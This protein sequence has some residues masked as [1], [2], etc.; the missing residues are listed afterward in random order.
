MF[1]D[2]NL[3]WYPSIV[4]SN[5]KQITIGDLHSNA[6][7]LV[8]ILIRHQVLKVSVT[9]YLKLVGCYQSLA[10]NPQDEY[11]YHEF[12]KIIYEAEVVNKPLIRMIGDE[13]A[14]RGGND[15][16]ILFILKKLQEHQ[17]PYRI[18]LS[19]H[20]L[21]F[22]SRYA[23]LVNGV[24]QKN[25]MVPPGYSTSFDTLLLYYT[26]DHI[27]LKTIKNWVSQAYLPYLQLFDY[28]LHGNQI[29]LYTHGINGI[30]QFQQLATEFNIDWNDN[31]MVALA[32]TLEQLQ[33]HFKQEKLYP[34]LNAFVISACD[35]PEEYVQKMQW[36]RE[37]TMYFVCEN[38]SV[39]P[40]V[41]TR[42]EIYKGYHV[43]Y[44]HGHHPEVN[45]PQ[46]AI[47][48]DGALGKHIRLS[49]GLL[50][51]YLCYGE[52]VKSYRSKL[53]KQE[54]SPLKRLFLPCLGVMACGYLF[55]Q[56]SGN[57]FFLN[58]MQG[59]FALFSKDF[60][61]TNAMQKLTF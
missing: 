3:F 43:K 56:Y 27:E 57:L 1:N 49:Q 58:W 39:C 29:T 34:L 28:S 24:E 42:P 33:H 47:S 13:L 4:E 9:K 35:A 8:Y 54:T 52:D 23:A 45:P 48:L 41:L 21:C 19:N 50:M 12:L 15:L 51:E 5:E 2:V 26:N 20:G 59:Y 55:N 7:L 31:D 61:S 37:S 22:L 44:A 17:V 40:T 16:L 10:Q 32:T 60:N 46:N 53:K 38:R 30:E 6:L 36:F 18:I 25:P 14:D 11:S